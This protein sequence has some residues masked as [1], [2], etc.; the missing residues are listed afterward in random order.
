MDLNYAVIIIFAIAL[1]IM[2][3]ASRMR[4]KGY[5][6][7]NLAGRR[8]GLARL[9]GTLGAAEFNTATLIGSAGVSYLYGTVGIWYTSLVFI[10]VFGTYAF[11]V[12]KPYRRLEITTIAEFFERRFSGPLAEPTRALASFLT[13][14][15]T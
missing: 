15:F 6:D 11:T 14:T 1:I 10:V 8:V 7:F 2:A 9:V 13:L 3:V 4:T 5:E 12:A